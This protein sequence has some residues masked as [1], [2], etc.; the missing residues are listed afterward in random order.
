MNDWIVVSYSDIDNLYDVELKSND[1]QYCV[2]ECN[3][4]IKVNSYS[5]RALQYSVWLESEFE[6]YMDEIGGC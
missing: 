1:Y 3:R 2:D 4:M 5:K 6:Q